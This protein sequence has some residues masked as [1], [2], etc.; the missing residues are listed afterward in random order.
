VSRVRKSALA[1]KKLVNN[2]LLR[3]TFD[4]LFSATEYVPKWLIGQEYV[5]LATYNK[6]I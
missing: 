1:I 6:A 3:F 4:L 5:I 2:K